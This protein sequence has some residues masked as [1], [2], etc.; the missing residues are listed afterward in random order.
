VRGQVAEYM[1]VFAAVAATAII[2]LSMALREFPYMLMDTHAVVIGVEGGYSYELNTFRDGAITTYE[3]DY[4]A[5]TKTVHL[6]LGV[7]GWDASAVRTAIIGVLN[8]YGYKV[9]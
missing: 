6:S 1:L 7:V 4:N 2:V 3:T 8:T 9:K 5:D